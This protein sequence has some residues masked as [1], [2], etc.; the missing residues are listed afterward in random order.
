MTISHRI[1][2]VAKHNAD[3]EALK[4][5]N[6]T[7]TYQDMQHRVQAI[8]DSL[9]NAGVQQGS[10][11]AVF[12][13]PSADWV[14][15][16]LAIWHVGATYIPMDLRNSVSRLAAIAEAAKPSAILCD[17]ETEK[18]VSEL[19]STAT[20]ISV[21]GLPNT[22]NI[23]STK[24]RTN[25]PALILFTSGSTGTPK[26]II[27]HHSALRNTIEGPSKQYNIGA[28]RILQQSAFTFD[29][30][31]DQI[32]CGLANA[33]SVYVI[34][35]ED[36]LD[37]MAISK[38][39]AD[40]GITYTR[41]TPAEYASWI[42]YGAEHL[43]KASNWKFAWGGGERMP[44]SLRESIESL[45]LEGLTLY[46]SYGPAE[47]ITC[48]KMALPPISDLDD[49]EDA[50]EEIPAGYPLP[51]YLVYIV[52][53]NLSLLPQGATGEI[54]IGGPSL[55]NGY[56]NNEKLSGAHFVGNPWDPGVIYRT[57]DLGH[58][59]SDGAL[60]YRGRM[61]G[62]TQ[63]KIRGMRTDLQDIEA[64]IL[65]A[66]EGALLKVV[67]SVRTG[68]LLVAHVQF[69]P[70][71]YAAAGDEAQQQALLRSLRFML[72]LPAYMVPALFVPI[73]QMPVT[74]H[75]KTD[76]AAVRALPLPQQANA[77]RTGDALTATERKLVQVMKEIVPDETVDAVQ[78]SSQT[79]FFE[80]GGNSLLLVKLQ[81][82]LN[83]RFDRKFAL[84]DLF[85]AATL[86]A[87][88]AKIDSSPSASGGGDER[89]TESR[90]VTDDEQQEKGNQV[91][92]DDDEREKGNQI[93]TDD[94]EGEKESQ[95]VTSDSTG[96]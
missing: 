19:K 28:E 54:V 4:D 70:D 69:A 60:M 94:N 50:E 49:E 15:S 42:T 78:V 12:Q 23:T 90:I 67:V 6:G 64:C 46:N 65:A 71:Q 59:R 74:V 17:A 57:G 85:S 20:V 48:T 81:M 80:L 5:C 1:A 86:G 45:G 38:I 58:F 43:M 73:A 82:L 61:A 13:Q 11:L 72:P 88:A 9:S 52:D 56:L 83:T 92:T 25:T 77:G 76:R 16:L 68:D 32:L 55:A 89:G 37:P 2:E 30:S 79:S 3:E 63:V 75:G 47:T 21:T 62:D 91:V 7:Y 51:N 14:C 24:A 53:R 35:Q 93:V 41:A 33:G 29:F 95:I 36:R 10:R 87:M 44:P 96:V 18:D 84:I 66:A 27:M 8:S 34:S 26:G 39:I 31:L 40:E 22:T